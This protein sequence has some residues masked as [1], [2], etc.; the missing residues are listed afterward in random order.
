MIS[1]VRDASATL[2]SLSG[3][4]ESTSALQAKFLDKI[5]AKMTRTRANDVEQTAASWRHQFPP[6]YNG[7]RDDFEDPSL[8]PRGDAEV[9]YPD[10]SSW[11]D[12]FAD[13]GFE[14]EGNIF[15][16]SDAGLPSNNLA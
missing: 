11:S 15:L 10:D 16:L 14:L 2:S 5:A 7:N 13:S 9:P 8:L 1:A 4:P 12:I 6:E 3:A